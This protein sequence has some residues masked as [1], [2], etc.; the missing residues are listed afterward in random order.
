MHAGAHAQ[1][2]TANPIYHR[3]NSDCVA[4]FYRIVNIAVPDAATGTVWQLEAKGLRMVLTC[5]DQFW[6]GPRERYDYLLTE[7]QLEMLA[8]ELHAPLL[9]G[10]RRCDGVMLYAEDA[11]DAVPLR[12]TE[13][14]RKLTKFGPV[15][16]LW[17][18]FGHVASFAVNAEVFGVLGDWNA[19]RETHLVQ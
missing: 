4:S 19:D 2:A 10:Q 15:R 5:V 6:V 12:I 18:Q 13:S 14:E 8:S 11:T 1:P 16:S 3:C 9:L 7:P 17:F